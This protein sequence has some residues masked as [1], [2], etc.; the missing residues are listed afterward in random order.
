MWGEAHS[1]WRTWVLAR[2]RG[3]TYLHLQPKEWTLVPQMHSLKHLVLSLKRRE[4][5]SCFPQSL[6]GLSTLETLR[7]QGAS[8]SGGQEGAMW[9][10]LDLDALPRLARI[11]IA[12]LVMGEVLLS[13]GC[14]LHV[15]GGANI[16]ALED[17]LALGAAGS[18]RMLG[19]DQ[20]D[21]R[22]IEDLPE[23]LAK[24]NRLTCLQWYVKKLG[25]LSL[26]PFW[27]YGP[28]FDGLAE[29][30]LITDMLS[31]NSVAL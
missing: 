10:R 25:S 22:L 30:Y 12:G 26:G 2:A 19:L 18:L 5:D 20:R 31:R 27:L 16:L 23:F 29:L 15:N 9:P 4:P 11:S 7:L 8:S 21:E 14:R 1:M 13:P 3:L 6:T 24:Q 28:C 17:W